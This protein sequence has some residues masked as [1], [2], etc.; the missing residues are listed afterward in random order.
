MKQSNPTCERSLAAISATGLLYKLCGSSQPSILQGSDG[1]VYVVKFNGFPGRQSLANEVVG[2]E[3]IRLMGLPTPDWV[4]IELSSNFIDEN[5]GLWFSNGG[6]NIK[7]QPGLHFGS[8]LIEATEDQCTYQIIPHSWINKIENRADFL[9]VLV[10]DLWANNC[11]RRQAVFLSD[12]QS[13]LHASFIDNDFMFGGKFGSDITCPRRAMVHDLD[14]YRGLWDPQI[15]QEWVHK[16]DGIGEG[17]IRRIVGS[18][19]DGWAS[20]QMLL[21]ITE[22]LRSRRAILSCL[23]NDAENV[24]SSGYSVKYHKARYATEPG[25]FHIAPILPA[26]P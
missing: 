20:E 15:V 9:G 18:V 17:A 21:E 1:A 11:D 5:P 14:V 22:Q 7:P 10:L 13:Q 16:L 6:R 2:T 25:S 26:L 8:R 4:P 3:L 23:L 12:A 24:L 19:P